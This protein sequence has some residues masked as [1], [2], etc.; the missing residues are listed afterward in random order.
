[1]TPTVLPS[2]KNAY[3]TEVQHLS[4]ISGADFS[5]HGGAMGQ[6]TEP[7]KTAVP[8]SVEEEWPHGQEAQ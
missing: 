1:M 5:V 7:S 4:E 3:P 6:A 2:L 8:T